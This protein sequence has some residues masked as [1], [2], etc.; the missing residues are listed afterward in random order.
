MTDNKTIKTVAESY[1][2]MNNS[3]D[4][5]FETMDFILENEAAY[6]DEAVKK[7]AAAGGVPKMPKNPHKRYGGPKR[8]PTAPYSALHHS[9]IANHASDVA[10]YY[11]GIA[12]KTG[13]AKDHRRAAEAHDKARELHSFAHNIHTDDVDKWDHHDFNASV[14]R[15]HDRLEYYHGN[16]AE[17][18]RDAAY[19][20]K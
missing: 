14:G 16:K 3:S 15:K 8:L 17:D 4:L 18:H 9:H 19:S 10:K 6:I 5:V 1:R 13:K 20:G 11:S 2:D 12:K 7:S